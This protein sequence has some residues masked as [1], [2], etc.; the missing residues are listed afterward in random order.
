MQQLI[1]FMERK[2]T[3]NLREPNGERPTTIFLV[4]RTI[5]GKQLK[6]NIGTEYKVYPKHWNSET[7]RAKTDNSL[8][9]I[10]VDNYTKVNA[11]IKECQKLFDE[12]KDYIANNTHQIYDSETLLRKYIDGETTTLERNPIDWFRHCIDEISTAKESSKAQYKR[13]VTV[14]ERFIKEKKIRLNTFSQFNYDILKKYEAYL[15]EKEEKIKTINNKISTLIIFLNH[16]ENYS[17]IDLKANRITKYRKLKD[18]VKDDDSIYLTEE[19]IKKIYNLELVGKKKTV[20]DIFIVQYYLGQRISDMGNLKN[21]TIREN[22]IE[23]YQK[24]TNTLVTIPIINPTVTA[25]LAEYDYSFPEKTVNDNSA[26]NLLLKEIAKEAGI[27]EE[28]SYREQKG[29]TIEIKKAEKWEL[30]TTHTARHSFATNMLLKGYPKEMIKKITGH[31]TDSA[32]Q[33][34]NNITSKDA[35]KFILEKENELK[36]GEQPIIKQSPTS[37]VVCNDCFDW[38]SEEKIREYLIAKLR[39]AGIF[40]TD[41]DCKSFIEKTVDFF[42]TYRNKYNREIDLH[43]DMDRAILKILECEDSLNYNSAYDI[44]REYIRYDTVKDANESFDEVIQPITQFVEYTSDLSD[45]YLHIF[46]YA[47][48]DK[49]DELELESKLQKHLNNPEH[50]QILHHYINVLQSITY[51]KIEEALPDGS[52]YNWGFPPEDESKRQIIRSNINDMI[53][54]ITGIL[55]KHR[56]LS[57]NA[58]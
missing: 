6:I 55:N 53:A 32:F 10:Y 29:T 57:V 23:L 14:F 42:H 16:A 18:E 7:Q 49:Q 58:E 24:K 34:Y 11:R 39:E 2:A 38:D 13:D 50:F 52:M 4:Y 20:R 5:E 46:G 27:N 30:I 17:L 48:F 28:V 26:Q 25:I 35:S 1:F 19:E 56:T 3:F 40:T 45:K 31:K 8:A 43:S 54:I 47:G 33:T 9:Q 41:R 22:E 15:I 21:A 37:K 51:K 12:W 36:K 44:I